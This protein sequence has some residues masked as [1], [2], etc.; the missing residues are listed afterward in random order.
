VPFVE[1]LT[2]RGLLYS[3]LRARLGVPIAVGISAGLFAG[4]HGY[5]LLGLLS[6]FWS[7][8]LWAVAYERTRSLLPC[9]VAHGI[10]NLVATVSFAAMYRF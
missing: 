6:V 10:E 9:F 4:G 3:S 1:E 5:G 2:F 8:T 7:G